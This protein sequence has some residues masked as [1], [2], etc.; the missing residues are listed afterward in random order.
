MVREFRAERLEEPQRLLGLLLAQR[1]AGLLQAGRQSLGALA[2]PLLLALGLLLNLALA[3]SQEPGQV[4]PTG[5]LVGLGGR[6]PRAARRMPARPPG[7]SRRA[8]RLE[9]AARR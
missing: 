7:R 8:R 5:Q 3:L 4:R 6:A 2:I 1:L 9:P